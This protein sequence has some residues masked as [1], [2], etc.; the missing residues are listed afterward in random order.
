MYKSAFKA[1][2]LF[3]AAYLLIACSL[4]QPAAEVA[5][6]GEVKWYTW[7]EAIEANKKEQKK[8]MVDIY[9]SWCGWCKVMDKKTFAKSDVAS[10]LNEHFYPVK[11]DAEQREAIEFDGHTFNFIESGRR[12]VHQLAY[13]LLDGQM[14][15]PAIVFLDGDVKRITISKGYTEAKDF[16]TQLQFIEGNHY[17]SQS[18]EQFK[19][20]SK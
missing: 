8:I 18:F 10:Y 13:S 3:F 15:Y 14:S 6:K 5:K 20:D 4:S 9:T 17:Q 19:K 16:M 7:E 11:L 2:S 12:G 1:I